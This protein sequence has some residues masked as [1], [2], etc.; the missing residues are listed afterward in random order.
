MEYQLIVAIVKKG[1]A[2]EVVECAREAGANGATI[3]YARGTSIHT[4]E[5]FLGIR[6]TNEQEMVW[7]IIPAELCEK[8][9]A[10]I[11]EVGELERPGMGV[12]MVLPILQVVG[13]VHQTP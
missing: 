4:P 1:R 11:V 2:N 7:V 5:P 10:R 9:L 6:P 3:S 13:L 8:V 12:A